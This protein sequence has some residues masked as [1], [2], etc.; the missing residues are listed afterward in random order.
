MAFEYSYGQKKNTKHIVIAA[1]SAALI[2]SFYLI[3]T[4]TAYVS[5]TES[6]ESELNKTKAALSSVEGEKTQCLKD[7]FEKISASDKCSAEL[8]EKSANLDICESDRTGMKTYISSVNSSL[9]SCMSEKQSLQ[10][11]YQNESENFRSLVRNSAASICCSFRD[12]QRGSVINW[13][14][15]NN[16]II[17][18]GSYT[19]N[20]S[21]G[22][23]NY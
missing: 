14:I 6:L 17:C 15:A 5:Y 23:T 9:S 4:N 12:A 8:N 20:C 13:G 16:S 18:E 11:L 3:T 22:A 1:V 10:G 21:T 7:L 19:V 2:F